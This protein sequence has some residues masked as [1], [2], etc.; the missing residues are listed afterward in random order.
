MFE[1]ELKEISKIF[2]RTSKKIETI[3]DILAKGEARIE[4][5][6][7]K[8]ENNIVLKNIYSNGSSVSVV[9]FPAKNSVYPIH[10]HRDTVEY[11]I[12]TKGSF[13]IIFGNGYRILKYK[14]CASIP[15]N[16]LHSITALEENCE[17]LA[18]CIPFEEA[19]KR[20]MECL[21]K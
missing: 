18:I 15:E 13:G 12:C 16:M 11:L 17:M 20:S 3:N 1:E 7:L 14:E 2:N 10:C 6:L 5:K 21:E 19:Y 8:F 9:K 4:D